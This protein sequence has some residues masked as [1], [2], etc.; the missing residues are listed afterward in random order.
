MTTVKSNFFTA[1]SLTL[2]FAIL[3]VPSIMVSRPPANIVYAVRQLISNPNPDQNKNT[4]AITTT[5]IGVSNISHTISVTG[6]ATTTVKPDNRPRQVAE[7]DGCVVI[8]GG[9]SLYRAIK[10]SRS[11]TAVTDTAGDEGVKDNVPPAK[12][13]PSSSAPPAPNSKLMNRVLEALLAAGVKRNETSTSSFNVSPNYNYSQGRN[14]ITGFTVTNSLQI[15]SSKIANVSEWLD[16]A[17][18]AGTNTVNSIDFTQSDKKLGEI[19]NGLI[20][21]AIDDARTQANFAASALGL[22]VMGVRS[23]TMNEFAST[24]QPMPFALQK[25]SVPAPTGGTPI[26]SGQQQVSESV[27]ITFLAG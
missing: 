3:V 6:S 7:G 14:I 21:L 24:P 23:I 19:K 5:N 9:G 18:S 13:P 11:F 4:T 1:M 10:N 16:T 17:I 27:D 25:L 20:K 12:I 15:E 2:V 22:K 8:T 26:I